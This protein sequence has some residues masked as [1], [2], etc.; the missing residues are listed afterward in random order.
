MRALEQQAGVLLV[1]AIH[2]QRV[3]MLCHQ[4]FDG[5]KRFI[6]GL[7][8]KLQLAQ[9]LRDD[10][11]GFLVRTKKKGLVAHSGI[12]G[13]PVLTS[14]VTEVSELRVSDQPARNSQLSR[15]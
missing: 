1:L 13:T 5:G 4:S 8:D 11:G 15:R 14:K 6:A 3:E 12:V 9:N 10:T 2:D 7:D